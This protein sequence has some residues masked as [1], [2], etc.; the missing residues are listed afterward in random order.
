MIAD[1][2]TF[3]AFALAGLEGGVAEDRSEARELLAK[4]RENHKVGLILITERLARSIQKDV[5][6]VRAGTGPPLLVE[7]PDLSGPLPAVETLL[8]RLR[9]VMGIPK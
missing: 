3:L 6:E 1:A 4:A 2:R 7:I 8:E 9:A 5:D